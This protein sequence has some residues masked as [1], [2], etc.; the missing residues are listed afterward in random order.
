MRD[1]TRVKFD[2]FSAGKVVNPGSIKEVAEPGGNGNRPRLSKG[3][4]GRAPRTESL[5]LPRDGLL[6][7]VPGKWTARRLVLLNKPSGAG[8]YP[9]NRPGGREGFLFRTLPSA[10]RKLQTVSRFSW[11]VPGM[12]IIV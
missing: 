5:T 2:E 7:G 6:S 1:I 3:P 9:G 11:V 12:H 4:Y 8:V 10:S